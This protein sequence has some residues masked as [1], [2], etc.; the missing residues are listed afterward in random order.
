[1]AA[2]EDDEER[3]IGGQLGDQRAVQLVTVDLAILL[4]V[5]WHNRVVEARVA[6]TVRVS[7]LATMSR[8]M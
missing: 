1:M 4:E 7:H 5:N 3:A 6:V 8:V 2:V